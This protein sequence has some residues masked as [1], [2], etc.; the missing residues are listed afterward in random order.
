[1][2]KVLSFG[3]AA[4]KSLLKLFAIELELKLNKLFEHPVYYTTLVVILHFVK[5]V[6]EQPL[7]YYWL[8]T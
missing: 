3:N 7:N 2:K 8:F 6:A 4:S 5:F 1:M